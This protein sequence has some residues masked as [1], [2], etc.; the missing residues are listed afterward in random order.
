MWPNSE[1]KKRYVCI[2]KSV[3]FHALRRSVL[4]NIKNEGAQIG[5]TDEKLLYLRTIIN[6][7]H[8]AETLCQ[9]RPCDMAC[10][11]IEYR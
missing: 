8:C 6:H 10:R 4:C 11:C 3:L 1:S 9:A 2:K 5:D 7:G